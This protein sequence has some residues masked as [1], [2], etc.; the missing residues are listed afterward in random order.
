MPVSDGD[1]PAGSSPSAVGGH[2]CILGPQGCLMAC[3]YPS[4]VP[5]VSSFS[6]GEVDV[7]VHYHPVQFFVGFLGVHNDGS[8]GSSALVSEWG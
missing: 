2:V 5:E 7:A 4:L 1:S 6:F 8:G 3:S